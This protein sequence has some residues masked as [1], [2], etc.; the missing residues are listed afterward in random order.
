MKR[1]KNQIYP[2]R[3][4]TDSPSAVI[5]FG[6]EDEFLRLQA[7]VIRNMAEGV[8]VTDENGTILY[9]NPAEDRMFGYEPG[10]L[11]GHPVTVQNGYPDD[12]NA[13]RVATVI[14]ILKAGGSWTGEWLN[15]KKNGDLFYTY[16]RIT[17]AKANGRDYWVCVQEDITDRKRYEQSRRETADRLSLALSASGMGDWSWDAASDVVTMSEH[18]ARIFSIPPGPRMTWKDMQALLH[19]EDR[20]RARSEVE[21]VTAEKVDYAI[22]YRLTGEGRE[23]RWVLATG[24]PLYD[25][26]GLLTGMLGVVRDI[27]AEK[28]LLKREREA[29]ETAEVLNSV[30]PILSSELNPERLVQSITDLATQLIGAQFGALFH[31]VLNE[32]GESYALYTLSGVPREA[33]SKFPMPRNTAI[34]SPTFRG[35]GVIRSDDITKDPRYGQNAPHHGMPEG[36]LPVKSYLAVPV[37]S[38]SGEVLGGLFFGHAHEAMFTERHEELVGGIAGQAAIALD[39]A[40]LFDQLNRE[41]SRVEDTNT[42]L[43]RANS[44]LQQFA[45]SAS[46]DLQEPLRMVSI[47]SQMLRRNHAGRLDGK[48]DEHIG[49]IIEGATRMENLVRDLLAYTRASTASEDGPSEP[50]DAN[51]VLK[52]S[53]SSLQIAIR[54]T[55]AVVT[56][57]P[58]PWV[59][60]HEIHLDQLFQ[61]LIGNAIKYRSAEPPRIN[62]A[63]ERR[64]EEWVLSVQ[65]NGIGIAPDYREYIFGIFK[66]L[67]TA[68][69]YS[70][71]GIGLAICQRIVERAGGQIWVESQLGQG[72]T[73]FF[74]V[75]E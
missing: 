34:F 61:N 50:V 62:V 59:R 12:E 68:A 28:E 32:R 45:Y 29:R 8:S 56:A 39:N 37:T 22:E 27:T 43:R 72:S 60:L 67:H 23:R 6:S 48:A 11:I 33:F 35:Q 5:P 65:D 30:G 14:A 70:G 55:G 69:E 9:T 16:A 24:R 10:E 73:F 3:Q 26:D 44:D 51:E 64:G 21:R 1:E 20:D 7:Q 46:H 42:A 74:I 52:K 54:E 57:G 53:L 38:R 31:N 75:P 40:R 4:D 25:S 66:R 49:Y 63:A 2:Q 19:P 18:A 36:H 13:R 41:R 47:Y 58:L 17:P 15:R 71:T